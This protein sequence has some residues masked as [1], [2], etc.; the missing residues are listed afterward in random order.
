MDAILKHVPTASQVEC[1]A[2]HECI[3]EP[4][5]K[6]PQTGQLAW[7]NSIAR[8]DLDTKHSTIVT[9]KNEIDLVPI[10]RTPVPEGDRLIHPRHLTRYLLHHEGLDEMAKFGESRCITALE[11]GTAQPKHLR[12]YSRVDDVNLGRT[13]TAS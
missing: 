4:L 12:T 3:A 8:L 9:L 6:P 10:S 7:V 1:D 2:R 11:L 5:A 13:H